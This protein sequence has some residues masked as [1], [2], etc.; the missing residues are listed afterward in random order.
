MSTSTPGR[1]ELTELA[2]FLNEIRVVWRTADQQQ[3][4]RIRRGV[5]VVLRGCRAPAPPLPGHP[6]PLAVT[7]GG[8]FTERAGEFELMDREQLLGEA[9]KWAFDYQQAALGGI[10]ARAGT[11]AMERDARGRLARVQGLLDPRQPGVRTKDLQMALNPEM[12]AGW[13]GYPGAVEPGAASAVTAATRKG[14]TDD[15][16][17]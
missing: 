5:M 14:A 6:Q 17:F 1:A 13:P 15:S 3:R 9:R 8:W 12:Y 4:D 10:R 11:E 7:D 16:L 2:A